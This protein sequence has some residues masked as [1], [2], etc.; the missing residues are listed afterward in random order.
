MEFF[1]SNTYE[2][3]NLKDDIIESR[4]LAASQTLVVDSLRKMLSKWRAE[5]GVQMAG[6]NP[7][8][9]KNGEIKPASIETFTGGTDK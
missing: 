1:E 5:T 2:L 3:Y 6:I 9:N 8:Y 7:R 4:N